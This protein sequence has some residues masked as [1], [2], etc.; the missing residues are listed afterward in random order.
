MTLKGNVIGWCE[1]VVWLARPQNW[2]DVISE[3]WLFEVVE[4]GHQ[5]KLLKEEFRVKHRDVSRASDQCVGG[6]R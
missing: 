5:K 1:D 6:V 2:D 4:P 3:A